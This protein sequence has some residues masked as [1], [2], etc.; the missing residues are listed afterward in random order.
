[1]RARPAVDGDLASFS[2]SL[3]DRRTATRA[4]WRVKP[5]SAPMLSNVA[6]PSRSSSAAGSRSRVAM[7]RRCVG[8]FGSLER[9]LGRA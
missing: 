3:I 5:S 6:P 4:A 8:A 2:V 1:M 9:R 7:I